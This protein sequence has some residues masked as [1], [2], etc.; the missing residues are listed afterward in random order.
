[1]SSFGT[2][3]L[4]MVRKNNQDSY[5]HMDYDDRYSIIAVADGLG[6][7]N[8]GEVASAYAVDELREFFDS[9]K[10]SDFFLMSEEIVSFIKNINH[11]IYTMSVAS[12]SLSGM[13]TTLTMAI[14]DG[15]RAVTYHVGDSRAYRIGKDH[16][17][18][19]TKD[20]SLV[21]YMLD[22]GQITQNEALHHP[23]KNIITRALG[24]DA[25]I[26]VDVIEST[27]E[28]NDILMVCSD[29]LTNNVSNASILEIVRSKRLKSA[30]NELVNEANRN[31]GSDNITVVMYSEDVK[32]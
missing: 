25:D 6:G 23:Q 26:A 2:T 7:H 21:Q 32:I 20:H 24:T 1:M 17:E 22:Q 16:I 31:G 15:K 12:E 18:Q 5:F 30:V 14:T 9:C 28:R 27:L 19:I 4:G 3:H 11:G 10:E 8:A 13:G 29:G